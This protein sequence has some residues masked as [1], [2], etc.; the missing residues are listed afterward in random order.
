MPI[1]SEEVYVISPDWDLR[2]NGSRVILLN[3]DPF[4]IQYFILDPVDALIFS[5]FDGNRTLDDVILVISYI[6]DANKE[7]AC[8]LVQ[9]AL[10]RINASAPRIMPKKELKG[11]DYR[12][13]DPFQFVIKTESLEHPKKLEVPIFIGIA[14][15]HRCQ[16]NCIYC[17]AERRFVAPNDELSLAAW[18][19]IIGQCADLGIDRVEPMG[20]DFL[21]RPDAVDI[22]EFLIKKEMQFFLSTKCHIDRT[23]ARRFADI[24]MGNRSIQISMDSPNAEIADNLTRS[25]GFYQ[26]AIDS[27]RNLIDCGLNVRAKATL[28]SLNARQAPELIRMWCTMG[29]RDMM[30]TDYSRSFFRHDDRLF[31]DP[32]DSA[33]VADEVEKLRTEFPGVKIAYGAQARG[34]AQDALKQRSRKEEWENWESRSRCSAGSSSMMIWPDGIVT[35]CEQIPHTYDHI[36]GDVRK[37]TILEV[38]NSER[39]LE[40]IYPDREKFNGTVCYSCEHFDDCHRLS[41]HCFRDALFAYS[42][43]YMPPPLCPLSPD[44]PRMS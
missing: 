21:A 10:T 39:L 1:S 22:M 24:G 42:S 16:T 6:L 2:R 5:L 31:C 37:Q 36:V 43:R 4:Q 15:T 40:Y 32:N 13:Y 26:R 30:L 12:T 27:L 38:W 44:A 14:P 23:L 18:F 3:M 41:G 35:L 9:D 19:D 17:Y 11:V 25:P 28:T 7:S 20:G 33:W 34:V 29:V 8:N